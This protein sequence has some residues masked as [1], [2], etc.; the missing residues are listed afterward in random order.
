MDGFSNFVPFTPLQDSHHAP[1]FNFSPPI[2]PMDYFF[3]IIVNKYPQKKTL[4]PDSDPVTLSA[5]RDI[6]I[7]RQP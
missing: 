2:Y 1:Y 4:N 5:C 3:T 6:L 7:T